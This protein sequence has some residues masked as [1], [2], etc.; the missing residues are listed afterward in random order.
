MSINIEDLLRDNIKKI[1]PY[2]TARD[3]YK[4]SNVTVFLD[5]N[6]NPF[7]TSLNRYPDPHQQKLKEKIAEIQGIPTAKIFLGNGSDEVID[8]ITRAFCRPGIDKIM[9]HPPTYGMYQVAA[10]TNDNEVIKVNLTSEFQLNVNEILSHANENLKVFFICSPNNPTGNTFAVKDIERILTG[11]NTIVVIDEAYINFSDKASWINRL[12]EFPNLIVMQ[13]LSKAW[14]L[15]G[16]RLGMGFAS[17]RIVEVLSRIKL[18][19]NLNILT[20]QTA[21]TTLNNIETYKQNLAILKNERQILITELSKIEA[22]EKV[23]PSD[24]NY[25]LCKFKDADKTYN[26]LMNK[27]IIVR[28]RSNQLHCENCLRITVGTPEENIVLIRYLSRMKLEIG[29]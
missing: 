9:I 2:S 18:P 5:A 1:I 29:N 26:Y 12:A 27:G 15:A 16:I 6:E 14:G 13:T 28:N 11:L 23:Y 8:L 17:E 19:Y 10:Q 25:L 4:G 21:L 3:E 20:Q 24:G 22:V 7:D